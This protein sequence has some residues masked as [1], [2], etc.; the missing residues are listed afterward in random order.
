MISLSHTLK[1]H[2]L[3]KLSSTFVWCMLLKENHLLIIHS[4]MKEIHPAGGKRNFNFDLFQYC[5]SQ[6]ID[7]FFITSNM[8]RK[9]SIQ[10]YGSE[11]EL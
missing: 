9:S 10:E 6:F 4:V 1:Y 5:A 8:F 2:E 7:T 3:T 11:L